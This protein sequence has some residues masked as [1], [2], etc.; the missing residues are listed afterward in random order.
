VMVPVDHCPARCGKIPARH[1]RHATSKRVDSLPRC[2]ASLRSFRRDHG[3][4]YRQA[5]A[6]LC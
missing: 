2:M 3:S 1:C 5:L 6:H 4:G